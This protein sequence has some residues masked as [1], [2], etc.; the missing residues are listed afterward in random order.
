MDADQV[1]AEEEALRSRI[2]QLDAQQKKRFFNAVEK[3]I[4]DPDT[5]AVLNYLLLAGLHHFYLGK[6]TR[7]LINLVVFVVGALSVVIGFSF[8]GALLIAMILLLELPALFRSQLI[9]ADFNNKVMA[10]HLDDITH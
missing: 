9:V 1:A 8:I 2:Q 5:Y 7:G 6:W 4:K 10:R 3:Q